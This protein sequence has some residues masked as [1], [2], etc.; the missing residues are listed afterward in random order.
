M[1]LDWRITFCCSIL[2]QINQLEFINSTWITIIMVSFRVVQFFRLELDDWMMP[3]LS[4]NK[5]KLKYHHLYL[6]SRDGSS[7]ELNIWSTH[8]RSTISYDLSLKCKTLIWSPISWPI[9]HQLLSVDGVPG[10]TKIFWM[11]TILIRHNYDGHDY[12]WSVLFPLNGVTTY[13]QISLNI[14]VYSSVYDQRKLIL[15][16]E[17]SFSVKNLN[18]LHTEMNS[19]LWNFRSVSR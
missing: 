13:S 7:S 12:V 8:M 11:R 14:S 18:Y 17:D 4:L 2:I 6:L 9:Y 16:R 19:K 5:S 10:S 15:L 3:S 1:T